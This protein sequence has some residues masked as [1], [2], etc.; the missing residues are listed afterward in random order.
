MSAAPLLWDAFLCNLQDGEE[1][2]VQQQQLRYSGAQDARR[3]RGKVSNYQSVN[4]GVCACVRVCVWKRLGDVHHRHL[5][6]ASNRPVTTPRRSTSRYEMCAAVRKG[7]VIV[8]QLYHTLSLTPTVRA[9]G[10]GVLSKVPVRGYQLL[11]G[12]HSLSLCMCMAAGRK[13]LPVSPITSPH[14][15]LPVKVCRAA[16]ARANPLGRTN[17][18]NQPVVCPIPLGC[19]EVTANGSKTVEDQKGGQ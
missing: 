3:P 16:I 4:A 17:R 9:R 12:L 10:G 5:G 1:D 6:V 18:V 7:C 2:R 11:L 8:R 15:N 19:T 13:V 14:H